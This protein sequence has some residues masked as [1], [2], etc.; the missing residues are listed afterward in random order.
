MFEHVELCVVRNHLAEACDV[1]SLGFFGLLLAAMST[2]AWIQSA[3]AQRAL[4][5]ASAT[6]QMYQLELAGLPFEIGTLIVPYSAPRP[7]PLPLDSAFAW[8]P[9]IVQWAVM[10]NDPGYG[11]RL[12][13]TSTSLPS[14][15]GLLLRCRRFTSH[16]KSI[17]HTKLIKSQHMCI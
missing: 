13:V 1:T 3:R 4:V 6:S 15:Q 12:M 9:E 11:R 14:R 5:L 8:G 2:T 7:V 17:K 16:P 10:P